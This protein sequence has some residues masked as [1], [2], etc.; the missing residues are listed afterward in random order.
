MLMTVKMTLIRADRSPGFLR[1]KC[2]RPRPN[3]LVEEDKYAIKLFLGSTFKTMREASTCCD[4]QGNHWKKLSRFQTNLERQS[5]SPNKDNVWTSC[6]IRRFIFPIPSG[7]A[8][9]EGERI[10]WNCFIEH[11]ARWFTSFCFA[12]VAGNK[13][14]TGLLFISHHRRSL[15]VRNSISNCETG[16]GY[17]RSS[18]CWPFA[19][20]PGAGGKRDQDG[21]S[22]FLHSPAPPQPECQGCHQF[23]S[24]CLV[25][26]SLFSTMSCL[27]WV[28]SLTS[29]FVCY[30]ITT[31]Y[32]NRNDTLRC[33]EN[34]EAIGQ[35]IPYLEL[36]H[37]LDIEAL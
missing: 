15:I 6:E 3:S 30:G 26:F 13:D 31:V 7:V 1:D 14:F 21:S 4:F 37:E 28:Y 29:S 18:I 9:Q 32:A 17:V 27:V 20:Y 2:S 36:F 25:P 35:K 12:M 34:N 23:E 5:N 24:L 19:L 22:W 11:F 16:N 8:E 33:I 10:I